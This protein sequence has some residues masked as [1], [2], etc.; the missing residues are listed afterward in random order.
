M[1]VRLGCTQ[2][3]RKTQTDDATIITL[4]SMKLIDSPTLQRQVAGDAGEDGRAVGL[5]AQLAAPAPRI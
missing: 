1:G 2:L 3:A 5:R 4:V